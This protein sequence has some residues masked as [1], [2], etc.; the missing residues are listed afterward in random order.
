MDHLMSFRGE[1][2]TFK[3]VVEGIGNIGS[4]SLDDGAI[5]SRYNFKDNDIVMTTDGHSIDP[6]FFPGGDIGKLSVCGTLNDLLMMGGA[7]VYYFSVIYW[8]GLYFFL[9]SESSCFYGW[10]S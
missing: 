3:T 1:W 2:I 5:I 4:D 6:L 9:I 10:N 7:P 8:G